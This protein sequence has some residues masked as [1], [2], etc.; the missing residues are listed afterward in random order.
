MTYLAD[1]FIQ[2][3]RQSANVALCQIS[4]LFIELDMA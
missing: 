4:P 1:F 2:E 3:R